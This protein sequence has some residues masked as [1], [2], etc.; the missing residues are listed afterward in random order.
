MSGS[1]TVRKVFGHFWDWSWLTRWILSLQRFTDA[2]AQMGCLVY[3]VDAGTNQLVWKLRQILGSFDGAVQLP[4]CDHLRI[5]SKTCFASIDAVL[6]STSSC[7]PPWD[8]REARWSPLVKPR[9]K[10]VESRLGKMDGRRH[11][12][13]SGSWLCLGTYVRTWLLPSWEWIGPLI[14]GASGNILN[15]Y[16]ICR[17]IS[18]KIVFNQEFAAVVE[19]SLLLTFGHE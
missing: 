5:L 10:L 8:C 15:F 3:A 13:L 14:Q 16:F 18:S 7:Q 9:L 17:K 4:L 2:H 12:H 11:V 1:I 6:L 19:K